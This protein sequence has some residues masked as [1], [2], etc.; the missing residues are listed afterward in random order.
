MKHIAGETLRVYADQRRPRLRISHDQGHGFLD[1]AIPVGTGFAAKS[2][3]AKL[4]PARG[5]VGGGDLANGC[6]HTNIISATAGGKLNVGLSDISEALFQSRTDP[7]RP[8]QKQSTPQN[9]GEN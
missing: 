8:D 9:G 1:A 2:V 3:N 6:A 4:A 5:E 7:V